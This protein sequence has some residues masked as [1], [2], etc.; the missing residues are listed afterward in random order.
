MACVSKEKRIEIARRGGL[1]RGKDKESL[2][3]AG[4]KGGRIIL[5]KCGLSHFAKLGRKGGKT[6]GV[7]SGA[8]RRAKKKDK[9]EKEL[10]EELLSSLSPS[11]SRPLALPSNT[12]RISHGA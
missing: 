5:K 12:N 9:E 1:I 6:G 10:K 3:Q 11:M 4:K 7:N 8:V 2:S